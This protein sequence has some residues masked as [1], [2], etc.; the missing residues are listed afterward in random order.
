MKRSSEGFELLDAKKTKSSSDEKAVTIVLD[1]YN[2]N[3]Q[4]LLAHH[5][6]ATIK[7]YHI[8][9]TNETVNTFPRYLGRV[10]DYSPKMDCLIL[11]KG[12]LLEIFSLTTNTGRTIKFPSHDLWCMIEDEHALVYVRGQK[13]T[14]MDLDKNQAIWTSKMSDQQRKVSWMVYHKRLNQIIIGGQEIDRLDAATGKVMNCTD[15][16][17]R[18]KFFNKAYV[19]ETTGSLVIVDSSK[20]VVFRPKGNNGFFVLFEVKFRAKKENFD[21][22]L[23]IDGR[24]FVLDGECFEIATGA[25]LGF[26]QDWNRFEC[27]VMKN[28]K[29]FARID[30]NVHSFD[31]EMGFKEVAR[32]LGKIECDEIRRLGGIIPTSFISI[33]NVNP[34]ANFFT[35]VDWDS[36]QH[37]TL[38]MKELNGHTLITHRRHREKYKYLDSGNIPTYLGGSKQVKIEL[39]GEGVRVDYAKNEYSMTIKEYLSKLTKAHTTNVQIYEEN[40]KHWVSWYVTV[41]YHLIVEMLPADLSTDDILECY[42]QVLMDRMILGD[43]NLGRTISVLKVVQNL[44]DSDIVIGGKRYSKADLVAIYC[45]RL[46]KEDHTIIVVEFSL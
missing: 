24:F 19:R 8:D 15:Q 31:V 4:S 6:A 17:S 43:K 35:S 5:M 32:P 3:L 7:Q 13:V 2:K 34:V 46:R 25:C 14:K 33:P 26:I 1:D 11:D 36:E 40:R 18:Y 39:V 37:Y 41:N 21:W 23:I 28:S 38:D 9:L 30:N 20:M 42:K 45:S 10:I 12:D 29:L 22:F 16:L 44:M 27:C